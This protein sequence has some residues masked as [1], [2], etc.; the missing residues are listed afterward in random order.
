MMDGLRNIPSSF[1]S[2]RVSK[3]LLPCSTGGWCH[4]SPRRSSGTVRLAVEDQ[5]V[6]PMAGRAAA[7]AFA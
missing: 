7:E 1:R 2:D 5:P 6:H 3:P 4:P